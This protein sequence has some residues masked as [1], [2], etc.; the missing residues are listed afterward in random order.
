MELVDADDIWITK[1]DFLAIMGTFG[2]L[3]FVIPYQFEFI[4]RL[5]ETQKIGGGDGQQKVFDEDLLE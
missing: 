5:M 1:I 3:P 4:K 2:V